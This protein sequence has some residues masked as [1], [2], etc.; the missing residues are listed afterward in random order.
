[1][2]FNTFRK[3]FLVFS[4]QWLS[5]RFYLILLVVFAVSLSILSSS[6]Y[7][8][9]SFVSLI[10]HNPGLAA[11]EV[12]E[13]TSSGERWVGTIPG[14]QVSAR[15]PTT[16]NSHWQ[17]RL[18]RSANAGNAVRYTYIATDQVHQRFELPGFL[19]NAT[20]PSPARIDA[21]ANQFKQF[22]HYTVGQIPCNETQLV[23]PRGTTFNRHF[24]WDVD[25]WRCN[26]TSPVIDDLKNSCTPPDSLPPIGVVWWYNV[27]NQQY[28]CSG[29]ISQVMSNWGGNY[30]MFQDAC[31]VHDMCYRTDASKQYCDNQL[32]ENMSSLCNRTGLSDIALWSTCQ[33]LTGIV[34]ASFG[35]QAFQDAYDGDQ[36]ELKC[37]REKAEKC[38]EVKKLLP[39]DNPEIILN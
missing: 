13:V 37:V 35:H 4:A 2:I 3:D 36:A 11:Y 39:P 12:Y 29:P 24:Q 30:D 18:A 7:A 34:L 14:Q 6:A 38:K 17:F 9:K 8:Q 32:A 25:A 21:G 28:A 19:T 22:L 27:S 16:A 10:I 26:A 15:I 31:I 33:S 1:M 5:H 20:D 23:C